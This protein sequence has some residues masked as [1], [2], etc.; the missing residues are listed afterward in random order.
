[1]DWVM[2]RR[3][4]TSRSGVAF[5][6]ATRLAVWRK[7]AVVA[8]YDP[9]V[10]RKDACGAWIEWSKYGAVTPG[11][12]GWE[13]DHIKPVTANG[14]DELANLQPLQWENNRHKGDSWPTWSCKV[15]AA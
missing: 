14:G 13:I 7:A 5:A 10:H 11:G 8:G 1:M 4:G 12:T 6:E 15:D 9:S 3:H 2:A